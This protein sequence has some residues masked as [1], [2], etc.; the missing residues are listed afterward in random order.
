MTRLRV[1]ARNLFATWVGYAANLLVLFFLSPFIVH[2][3]GD[4]Q[5]GVWSLMVSLT[6]YLGLIEAG[7]QAG[8]GRFINFHLGRKE[9]EKVSGIASTGMAIFLAMGAILAVVACCL[10]FLMPSIFSKIPGELMGEARV[11]CLL[12]ALNLWISLL[13]APSRLIIQSK[14]RFELTS[15]IDLLVVLGRAAGTVAVLLSGGGLTELAFVQISSSL[16]G[17]FAAYVAARRVMPE[18]SLSARQ[19]SL[20][21][22][23]E[24]FGFSSWAFFGTMGYRLLV[25]TDAILIAMLLGPEWITI[26]VIGEMLVQKTADVVNQALYVFRPR[27]MQTCGQGDLEGVRQ[28]YQASATLAMGTAILF[29]VGMLVF[30]DSFIVLW[31]GEQYAQ[32][33]NIL[34]ILATAYLG[35]ILYSATHPV[36]AGMNRVRTTAMLTIGQAVTN[37]ALTLLFV[38]TFGM[39]LSGVAWGTFIPRVGFCILGTYLA[40]HLMSLEAG[41]LLKPI[42]RWTLTT[43]A[44]GACC[45]AVDWVVPEEGWL[46]LALKV[47]LATTSYIPL[48]WLLI[49]EGEQRA[50]VKSMVVRR[51]TAHS[52]KPQEG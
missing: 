29:V 49:M 19:V 35:S 43:G 52:I 2:S 12:V 41:R 4:V 48:V 3:L 18:L 39:G 44:F 13:A 5:Y 6:G 50:L 21:Q 14:E 27:I 7:T 15:G 11:L 45:L 9:L 31:M 42:F 32:S 37:L 23:R 36:F 16:F 17:L 47:C 33:H 8:L 1:Y 26:Y 46:G 22:F 24:L 51:I 25:S 34:V 20:A 28:Q 38:I 10:A 30:G 40:T